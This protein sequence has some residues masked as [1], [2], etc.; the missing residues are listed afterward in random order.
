MVLRVRVVLSSILLLIDIFV[1]FLICR[2]L[3]F[4]A[5]LPVLILIKAS[6]IQMSYR[7]CDIFQI[8][9]AKVGLPPHTCSAIILFDKFAEPVVAFRQF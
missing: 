5:I 9:N 6:V 4:C 8:S 7:G 1:V 2:R 3:N